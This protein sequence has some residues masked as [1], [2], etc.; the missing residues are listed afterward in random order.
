VSRYGHNDQA[1]PFCPDDT[2]DEYWTARFL[3]DCGRSGRRDHA[4]SSDEEALTMKGPLQTRQAPCAAADFSLGGGSVWHLSDKI[5][6]FLHVVERCEAELKEEYELRR[7]RAEA[8]RGWHR[9]MSSVSNVSLPPRRQPSRRTEK[10]RQASS[11]ANGRGSSTGRRTP[12]SATPAAVRLYAKP[13]LLAST[14]RSRAASNVRPQ[15]GPVKAPRSQQVSR[16]ASSNAGQLR[17]PQSFASRPPSSC[18]K[19]P[20]RRRTTARQ[21]TLDTEPVDVSSIQS[22]LL[23]NR[24]YQPARRKRLVKKRAPRRASK[25]DQQQQEHEDNFEDDEEEASGGFDGFNGDAGDDEDE[26][27]EDADLARHRHWIEDQA[28]RGLARKKALSSMGARDRSH[29]KESSKDSAYGYSGGESRLA[30]R[31]P[32]PDNYQQRQHARQERAARRRPVSSSHNARFG[33]PEER[34][35][36]ASGGKTTR[37]RH[38]MSAKGPSIAA[39]MMS[40]PESSEDERS[41]AYVNFVTN[42]TTEILRRNVYTDRALKDV[43]DEQL[44]RGGAAGNVSGR[45]LAVLS[46]KLRREFGIQPVASL[47]RTSLSGSLS[48]TNLT[49]MLRQPNKVNGSKSIAAAANK[50]ASTKDLD[51]LRSQEVAGLLQD[52]DLDD[53][54]IEDVLRAVGQIKDDKTSQQQQQLRLFDSLNISNLNISFNGDQRK[55]GDNRHLLIQSF[56]TEGS[57]QHGKEE[58]VASARQRREEHKR[59]DSSSSNGQERRV[60]A[61]PTLAKPPA[62]APQSQT[63]AAQAT[64]THS[65]GSPGGSSSLYQPE[66]TEENANK[67]TAD[68]VDSEISEDEPYID[69]FEAA[70]SEDLDD[71]SQ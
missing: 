33:L 56:A 50:E 31:E 54:V 43:L 18:S 21:P 57:D 24:N 64:D 15:A 32:T 11:S 48:E 68:E 40:A 71:E 22:R 13:P 58:R 60:P 39:R 52:A 23:A 46:A 17:H 10:S 6:K 3:D 26:E 70:V 63:G 38:G 55:R 8:K 25:Q 29:D 49:D 9:S 35:G 12:T 19:P 5:D 53:S 20:P 66:E 1:S 27:E 59:Q 61:R 14:K 37:Q 42:V 34:A 45:E 41:A 4:F 51:G 16:V 7:L 28:K 62:P 30:T 36:A 2:D 47:G 69:D 65:S 67:A 44:A